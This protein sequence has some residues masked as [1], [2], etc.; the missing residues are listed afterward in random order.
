MEWEH[1]FQFYGI[2]SWNRTNVFLLPW[3]Q[4]AAWRTQ[5]GHVQKKPYLP[6]TVSCWSLLSAGAYW[7]LATIL[8]WVLCFTLFLSWF[9]C[10]KPCEIRNI[11]GMLN[12]LFLFS[13]S[14]F[15]K[16]GSLACNVEKNFNVQIID[17]FFP[18]TF[19]NYIYFQ[20]RIP[21]FPLNMVSL[22]HPHKSLFYNIYL[23]I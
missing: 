10:P 16:V 1:V 3:S 12:K 11:L 7:V 13:P 22:I 14:F 21:Q 5:E 18:S 2:L 15:S 17:F 23:S 9:H 8:V 4:E 6:K 19:F 20:S